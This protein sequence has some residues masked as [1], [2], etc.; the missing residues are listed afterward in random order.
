MNKNVRVRVYV[1]MC[2]CKYVHIKIKYVKI[3]GIKYVEE[4]TLC[5]VYNVY[6]N[7]DIY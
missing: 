1:C 5:P 7:I 2:V 6:S 3:R 4:K